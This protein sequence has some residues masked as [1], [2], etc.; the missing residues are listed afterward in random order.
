MTSADE[1]RT[2]RHARAGVEL[3]GRARGVARRDRVEGSRRSA[4]AGRCRTTSCTSPRSSAF[5]LGDPLPD[6]GP[7]R[8][9]APREERH[10]PVNERWSSRAGAGRAPTRW[11]S[12]SPPPTPRIAQLRALDDDGFGADS[13]TP[14]GPG[15]VARPAAVPDLRLVG[16]RAGHAAGAWSAPATSTRPRPAF[17]TQMMLDVLPF[18]V[19]KK[20]GAPDGSTVVLSLSGPLVLRDGGRRRPTAAPARSTQY[21]PTRPS[22]L[23]LASDVY[24]RL[25]CGRIDPDEARRRR[26]GAHRRRRR[27]RRSASCA[28]STTCSE[29]PHS[30]KASH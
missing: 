18:V 26:R 11:P 12:S 2:R 22:A 3:D 9:P 5:I 14:M 29:P 6:G 19:G 16:A 1:R 30:E 28:S 21:P 25:A 20:V 7:A 13:W 17:S 4:R 15:T 23:S 24:G 8:R 27:A 10:R